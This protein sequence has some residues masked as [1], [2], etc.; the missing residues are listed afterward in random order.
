MV[1]R[2]WRGENRGKFFKMGFSTAN[3]GVKECHPGF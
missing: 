3:L 1:K 2:Y